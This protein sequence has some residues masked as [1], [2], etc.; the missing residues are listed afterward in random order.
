MSDPVQ[1]NGQA[2]EPL[3]LPVT[4]SGV[5]PRLARLD[6]LAAIHPD[7][8]AFA[9][10][11]RQ[12]GPPRPREPPALE[13]ARGGFRFR[14]GPVRDLTGRPLSLLTALLGAKDHRLT[15]DELRAA[16]RVNDEVA[17][18]PDS[19]VKDTARR[20]RRALRDADAAD[21]LRSAG[22]GAGLVYYLVLP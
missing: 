2:D 14:G 16:M 21:V 19:V 18:L 13:L 8:A 12:L 11:V 1:P 9:R 7:L 5:P 20:L 22:R 6:E 3:Y 4:I 15:A 17:D 10:E